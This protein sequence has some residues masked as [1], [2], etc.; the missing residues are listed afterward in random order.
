MRHDTQNSKEMAPS[1]CECITFT[2]FFVFCH[3]IKSDKDS[4]VGFLS[5][6]SVALPFTQQPM[7]RSRTEP[8]HTRISM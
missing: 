7:C 4:Q 8:T 1:I 6:W 2:D 3:C 5:P